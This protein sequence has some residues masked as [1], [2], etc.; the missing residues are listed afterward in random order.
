VIDRLIEAV[1]VIAAIATD[2]LYNGNELFC[3][4][5]RLSGNPTQTMSRETESREM[6]EAG[7]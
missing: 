5:L 2:Y 4:P 1:G 3:I 7:R 6:I